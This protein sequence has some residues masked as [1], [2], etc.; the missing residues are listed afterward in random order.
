MN[1]RFRPVVSFLGPRVVVMLVAT[2]LLGAPSSAQNPTN[3]P[4]QETGNATP[5]EADLPDDEEGFEPLFDGQ[6][7]AGWHGEEGLWR[8][9]EETLIG[10]TKPDQLLETNSF[11]V[12]EQ[13]LPGDFELRLLFRIVAGNSGVQ[14][15][16]EEDEPN[17]VC[18][19]QAD[20]DANGTYMGII[21]EERKRGILCQ[22]G[23]A[24][25]ID[26]NGERPE[27]GKTGLDEETFAALAT[28]GNW[29][30]YRIRAVGPKIELFIDG[31]PTALLD[32]QQTDAASP[33]GILA[34]QMHAGQMMHVEF[35]NIRIRAVEAK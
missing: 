14:F 13:D 17:R 10:Q 3:P 23:E 19:Y 18:G 34:L 22:R 8:V 11:L 16:A 7:L 1:H 4:A 35:R 33:D 24:V 25:T 26:A 12:C 21:Y 28:D 29:H 27:P 30:D 31:H 9:E 32:D 20:I 5:A 2:A 15:R 6:S